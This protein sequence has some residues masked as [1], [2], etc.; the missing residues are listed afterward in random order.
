M[1]L[2]VFMSE[3]KLD[4]AA[5]AALVGDCTDHAVKKWRYDERLPRVEQ[6]RRIYAVTDGAVTPNDFVLHPTAPADPANADCP[7]S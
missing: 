6:M 3:H 1:K 4:D 7:V 5:M 2:S